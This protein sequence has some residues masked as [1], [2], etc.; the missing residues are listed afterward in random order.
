MF[1]KTYSIGDENYIKTLSKLRSEGC[2]DDNPRGVWGD[3]TPAKC[4]Y[5]TNQTFSYDIDKGDYPMTTLRNTAI[6]TGI[7]ELFTIYQEQT[8]KNADF[9]RIGVDWWD[10]WLDENESLGTAYSFNL[11]SKRLIP[12]LNPSKLPH[13]KRTR[14][15]PKKYTRP[16]GE[17]VI[18]NSN[19]NPEVLTRLIKIWEDLRLATQET[20]WSDVDVFL[21]EIKYVPGYFLWRDGDEYSEIILHNI[22]SEPMSLNNTVFYDLEELYWLSLDNTTKEDNS[23]ELYD[24]SRNQIVDLLY[25]LE[26]DTFSKRH[27]LSFFNWGS[28]PLKTLVECAFMN[29]FN[30]RKV[31]ETYYLDQNLIQRSSDYIVA[32]YINATQYLTLGLM[33]CSHLR[34][35]TGNNW[36][37][38]NFKYD[39]N[40]L[41]CY[42]RHIK[43]IDEILNNPS[44]E[45]EQYIKIDVNKDFFSINLN[46]IIIKQVKGI[47]KLSENLEIVQ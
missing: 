26:H 46:D 12:G 8:N 1:K 10:K 24:I 31:G 37:M 17:Y 42:D 11:E 30:V 6:K 7:K 2:I 47:P 27:M 18:D 45:G 36:V 13:N 22:S 16:K 43:F 32:S 29:V 9:K 39:V 21:T 38:G 41:H 5:L 40:N 19:I 15:K 14:Y 34:Y 28:Q 33:I 25:N 44:I 35:R 3:G 4:H 23:I 20:P